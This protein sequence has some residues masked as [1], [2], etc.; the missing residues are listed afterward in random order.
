MT[1]AYKKIIAASPLFDGL[2]EKELTDALAFYRATVA[3]YRRGEIIGTI[4]DPFSFFALVLEGS[5]G[6]HHDDEEGRRTVMAFVRRGQLFGESLCYL[7]QE[8]DVYAVALE[9]TVLLKLHSENLRIPPK[10]PLEFVLQ[11]L[12]TANL[13]HRA[14]SLNDRI[15]LLSHSTIRERVLTMLAAYPKGEW[16]ALPFDRTAMAFYLGVDRSA[17][18]RELGKLRRQG[19][20]DFR[21]N[22]FIRIQ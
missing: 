14:L 19:V 12:F 7:K 4:S 5:V 16:V 11:R 10:T 6:V 20:I 21:K 3:T 18:S 1:Q 17:L 22:R 15:Q 13:A 9:D 8:A 2:S